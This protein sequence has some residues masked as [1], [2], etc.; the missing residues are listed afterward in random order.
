MCLEFSSIQSLLSTILWRMA[1]DINC[2]KLF[3]HGKFWFLLP[4]WLRVLLNVVV[5]VGI[6]GHL[7]LEAMLLQVILDVKCS[8]EKSV[9]I[10]VALLLCTIQV[11]SFAAAFSWFYMFSVSTIILFEGILFLLFWGKDSASHCSDFSSSF[12]VRL[13]LLQCLERDKW[14]CGSWRLPLW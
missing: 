5:W 12:L 4:L 3:C 9:V 13:C 7:G 10:L 8:I 11:F 2:F 6:N 14:G 1:L